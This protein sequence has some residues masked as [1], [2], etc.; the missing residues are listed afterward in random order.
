MDAFLMDFELQ[1]SQKPK[2]ATPKRMIFRIR[3]FIAFNA[4]FDGL[5]P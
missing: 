3:F 1:K 2:K 4:C 5:K